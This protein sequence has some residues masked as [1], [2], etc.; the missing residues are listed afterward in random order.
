MQIGGPVSSRQAAKIRGDNG[1]TQRLVRSCIKDLHS[2]AWRFPLCLFHL[3]SEILMPPGDLR[4]LAG[5]ALSCN[6]AFRGGHADALGVADFRW[7]AS[8]VPNFSRVVADHS[9]SF[10]RWPCLRHVC[11]HYMENNCLGPAWPACPI[12]AYVGPECLPPLGCFA[13]CPLSS[14]ANC[15]THLCTTQQNPLPLTAWPSAT[16]GTSSVGLPDK[17][18]RYP[19]SRIASLAMKWVQVDFP[20]LGTFHPWKS[21]VGG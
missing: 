7:P 15:Q 14:P 17:C 12:F 21:F 8:N 2:E 10:R 16:L 5:H 4:L 13:A 11:L 18:V 3:Q 20:A 1:C 19:R 9:A 6:S